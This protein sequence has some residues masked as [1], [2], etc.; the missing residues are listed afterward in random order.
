MTKDESGMVV[1]RDAQVVLTDALKDA[2]KARDPP[3]RAATRGGK[4][5]VAAASGAGC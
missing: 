4:R 5:P 3:A 1:G 2:M